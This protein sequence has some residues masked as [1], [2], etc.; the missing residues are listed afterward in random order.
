MSSSRS[1]ASLGENGLLR[2][3]VRDHGP[4]LAV[5]R[6]AA[7]RKGIGLSNTAE[8]LERLYGG[9]HPVGIENA[10]D[11][12]LVVTLLVPFHVDSGAAG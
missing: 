5:T 6:D 9:A 12:G 8:R 7:L 3:E 1:L 2:L 10:P 4:G 11:G